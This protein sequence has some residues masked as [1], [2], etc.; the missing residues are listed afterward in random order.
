MASPPLAPVANEQRAA[1]TQTLRR[2]E[3]RRRW[4]DTWLWLPRSLLPG[5]ALGLALLL[6]TRLRLAGPV[7]ELLLPTALLAGVGLLLL[8]ARVWLRPRPTLTLARRFEQEFALSERLSTALELIEGRI[9]SGAEMTARQLADAGARARAVNV[10]GQLPLRSDRRA[11]GLLAL[12]LLAVGLLWRLPAPAGAPDAADEAQAAAIDEAAAAVERISE[13]LERDEALPAELREQLQRELERSA[14]LLG[15]DALSPEEAFAALSESADRLEQG[16][17]DMEELRRQQ[18]EALAGADE[19]GGAQLAEALRQLENASSLPQGDDVA[20]RLEQAAAALEGSNP[21]L[22]QAIREALDALREAQLQGLRSSAQQASQML[23]QQQLEMSRSQAGQERLQA[24]SQEMRDSADRIA[25]Q[26]GPEALTSQRR[27]EQPSGFEELQGG[28]DLETQG[29]WRE[30]QGRQPGQNPEG[31]AVP[32]SQGQAGEAGGS[33]DGAQQG[34]EPGGEQTGQGPG[35][36]EAAGPGGQAGDSPGGAGQDES[37]AGQQGPPPGQR[38]NPD[39]TGRGEFAPVFAPRRIGASEGPELFLET[40]PGDA[41]LVEGDFAPNPAGEALVPW[42]EIYND[43]R[44][45]ASRALE[46]DYIPLGLRDVV[47][48]YFSALEPGQ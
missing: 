48:D 25:R 10:A 21:E 40:D 33:L 29:Q 22:A 34:I 45:A 41:P 15:R 19:A 2:W 8:L 11:W 7:D 46:S 20:R 42:N 17:V 44:D 27:M 5:L 9:H 16:A 26:A 6:W 13:E 36:E 12:T 35:R 32:G 28:G 3:R 43:Y 37:L 4:R 23:A 31:G 14:A 39:G 18:M 30:G 1:L 24:V 47:H 38:N